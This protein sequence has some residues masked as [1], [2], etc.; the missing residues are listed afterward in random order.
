MDQI[1]LIYQN[2]PGELVL[3]KHKALHIE[4]QKQ[5]RIKVYC[6][7]LAEMEEIWL[8]VIFLLPEEEVLW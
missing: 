2:L 3:G 6:S 5:K 4:G 8:S 1:L 7:T